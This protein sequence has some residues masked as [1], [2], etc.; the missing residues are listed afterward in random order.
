ML[1]IFMRKHQTKQNDRHY[2][3]TAKRRLRNCLRLRGEGKR[4]ATEWYGME[5][6]WYEGHGNRW[7]LLRLDV[8]DGLG[9]A[10]V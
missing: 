6:F 5:S 7:R 8:M 4:T 9:V 1:T 3:M 2:K 10:E